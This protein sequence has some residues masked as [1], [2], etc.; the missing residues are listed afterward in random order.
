MPVWKD[1]APRF[2]VVYDLFGNAKTALKF[3]VNRYNESRTTQ[4]AGRYNPLALR[5]RT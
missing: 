5:A 3:S 1:L 2:G 4:F